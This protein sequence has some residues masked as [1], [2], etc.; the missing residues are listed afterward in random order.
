MV[1]P[2]ENTLGAWN[3]GS[4]AAPWTSRKPAPPLAA[5]SSMDSGGPELA[6]QV[7]AQGGGQV[8]DE[9]VAGLR[10]HHWA[11]LHSVAL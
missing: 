9:L 10:R 11:P 3:T 4:P 5:L 7:D 8:A 2:L 1:H 6:A